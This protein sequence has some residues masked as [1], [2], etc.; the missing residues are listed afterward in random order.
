VIGPRTACNK[1]RPKSSSAY[2]L[3]IQRLDLF[4]QLDKVIAQVL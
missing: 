3:L 4:I 1:R 2:H